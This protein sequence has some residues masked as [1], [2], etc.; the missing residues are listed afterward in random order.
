MRPGAPA[1]PFPHP[2]R[3]HRL[4]ATGNTPRH[5]GWRRR[6][7]LRIVL[8]TSLVLVLT[9]LVSGGC[10]GGREPSVSFSPSWSPDGRAIAFIV[11]PDPSAGCSYGSCASRFELWV[12][13]AGG[14]EPRKL[15]RGVAG[16]Q[17]PTWSPDGRTIAFE[18]LTQYLLGDVYTIRRDGTHLRRLTRTG[19][20]SPAAWSPDGT[21]LLFVQSNRLYVMDADGSGQR[22]L[23]RLEPDEASWSPDGTTIAVTTFDGLF[24]IGA[25]GLGP[26]KLFSTPHGE[27]GGIGWSPDGQRISFGVE[28]RFAVVE[29]GGRVL[30]RPQ[31]RGYRWDTGYELRASWSP[32]RQAL[33]YE[34]PEGGIDVVSGNGAE[35]RRL[36]TSGEDPAWSP[37]GAR[38]AFS[39]GADIYVM[40]SDGTGRR[41]V[42]ERLPA[43]PE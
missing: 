27:I 37:D 29:V 32:D 40:N 33:A 20:D 28:G 6:G 30:V 2:Q 42:S 23:T 15:A 26:R 10:G 8:L 31:E 22:R 4:R 25:N 17:P 36:A 39:D 35:W 3:G 34:R 41:K 12:M 43:R 1:S 24:A 21:K 19:D 9:L 5:E 7:R 38:I 18:H 13:G 14:G 16:G 11:D